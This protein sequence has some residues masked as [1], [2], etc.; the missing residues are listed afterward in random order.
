[1][2]RVAPL[3]GAHMRREFLRWFESRSFALTLTIGRAVGPLIGLAIWTTA[4]PGSGVASYFVVL[5]FVR[6]V[7]VSYEEHTFSGRVYTGDLVEEL[8]RPEPVILQVVGESFA[9]RAWHLILGAPLLAVLAIATRTHLSASGLA[10]AVPALVLAGA[11]QFLFQF[12][13]ALSAFWTERVFGLTGFKVTAT[14]LLGG[15]AAP[16]YLM[17]PAAR[18]WAEALPFRAMLGFP[19]EIAAGAL[20]GSRIASGYA[21]QVV[22]VVFF[23]AAAALLWRRGTRRFTAVGG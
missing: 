12:A 10:V 1:V 7:T 20:N 19:A 23:A 6:L 16:I 11:I 17:P 21:W 4:L 22:W 3:L 9:L 18:A 14:F 13:V 15:E 5:L 8:L 2:T